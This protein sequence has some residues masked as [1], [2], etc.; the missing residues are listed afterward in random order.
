MKRCLVASALLL[1]FSFGVGASS[2]RADEP[3]RFHDL[4]LSEIPSVEAEP[5]VAWLTERFNANFGLGPRPLPDSERS[6]PAADWSGLPRPRLTND[7]GHAAVVRIRN[8]YHPDS[9]QSNQWLRYLQSDDASPIAMACGPDTG[10][11]RGVDTYLLEASRP[12][13]PRYTVVETWLDGKSCKG[14]VLRRYQTAV[15]PLAGGLAYAYRTHCAT[16][17]PAQ[18]ETLHVVI[19]TAMSS[20]ATGGFRYWTYLMEHLELPLGL[21]TSG[22]LRA[23]IEEASI[24]SW[25]RVVPRPLPIADVELRIETSFAA[26]E[27]EPT[28]VLATRAVNILP[29]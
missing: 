15:K 27:D 7:H 17:S 22:S 5:D 4:R 16:C 29:L 14:L 13:G 10:E 21:G 23:R 1:G 19:P 24:R 12:E 2:A 28:I 8:L 18:S 25:N 9:H 3:Y 11:P 20:R 6:R 26:G